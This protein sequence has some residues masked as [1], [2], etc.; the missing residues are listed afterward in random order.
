MD[1]NTYYQEYLAK[2]Q[3]L[4]CRRLHIIGNLVTLVY[5]G[6]VLDHLSPWWLLLA[7]FIIY[8]FAWS[9]HFFIEGNFPAAFKNPI[10]AKMADWRM[11]WDTIKGRIPL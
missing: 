1:F 10:R 8:P 3:N 5:I 7:P 6:V 2:H 11:I 9:G 4:W